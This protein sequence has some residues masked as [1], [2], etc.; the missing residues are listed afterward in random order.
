M[1]FCLLYD[2]FKG[3]ERRSATGRANGV[4]FTL[5]MQ[6]ATNKHTSTEERAGGR[7][8]IGNLQTC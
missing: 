5:P 3:I 6:N 1:V 7:H 8:G 4:L 2:S